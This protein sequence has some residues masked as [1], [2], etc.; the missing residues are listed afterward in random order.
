MDLEKVKAMLE[1]PTLRSATN[2]RS[3]HRLDTVYRKFTRNF[4]S[5]CGPLTK[6]MIEDKK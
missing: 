3:F 5:I 2:V 1:W 4:S 6:I